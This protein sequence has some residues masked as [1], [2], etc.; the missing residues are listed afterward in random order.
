[1]HRLAV[2]GN[3]I[4]Q[5]LSPQIHQQFAAQCGIKI[6]YEKI[7]APLGE[8]KK[9]ARD[10]FARGG[11]GCNVTV[12]FKVEAFELVD[13]R[14]PRAQQAGAVNTITCQRG[15]L[16]GDNTDGIGL[17]RDLQAKNRV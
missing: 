3:P 16:V 8:F 2:F 17:I 4:A 6:S 10:F 5:S 12:P 1:M 11:L 7:F 15:K 9:M 13:E 14:S